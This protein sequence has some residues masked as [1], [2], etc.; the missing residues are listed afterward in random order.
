M[1]ITLTDGTAVKV[2][3]ARK[4]LEAISVRVR[5]LLAAER[6]SALAI[7][8]ALLEVRDSGLAGVLLPEDQ[9]RSIDADKRRTAFATW[10][11]MLHIDKYARKRYLDHAEA[12]DGLISD[13]VAKASAEAMSPAFTR[14]LVAGANA[15]AKSM[16]SPLGQTLPSSVPP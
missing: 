14:A 10:C 11:E 6:A 13:G 12:V 4:R 1:P 7:G 9:R 3:E 8:R 5:D 15:E 2:G 16:S